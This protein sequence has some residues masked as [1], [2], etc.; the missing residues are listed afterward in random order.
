MVCTRQ[1]HAA[2]LRPE[3]A[4]SSNGKRWTKVA[5]KVQ[6]RDIARTLAGDLITLDKMMSWWGVMLPDTDFRPVSAPRLPSLI[7]SSLPETS[8]G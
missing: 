6:H 8:V 1:V 3:W 4:A 7:L 2:V 5:V